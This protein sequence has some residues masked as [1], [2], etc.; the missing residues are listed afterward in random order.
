MLPDWEDRLRLRRTIFEDGLEF[1]EAGKGSAEANEAYIMLN[2]SHKTAH[3]DLHDYLLICAK[4][5]SG[6]IVGAMDGHALGD[7]L[8]IGRSFSASTK[9]RELHILL[10]AAALAGR[11]PSF[12]VTYTKLGDFSIDTAGRLILFGRGMG[13]SAIPLKT[14]HLIFVRRMRKELDPISS[15]P[16]IA[17]ILEKLKIFGELDLD[18]HIGEFS[19][20]SVV[21]LIPL[22][23]SPD[24]REHLHELRDVV[25]SLGLPAGQLEAVMAT[26]RADYVSGRKDITPQAL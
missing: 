11:N 19:S 10:Y 23:L 9:T 16:E 3:S 26:L 5:R 18:A 14:T 1:F 21:P 2:Q 13:M 17:A 7:T 6:K 8:V 4:D 15:G 12:V 22:P 25:N 20:K 24:S